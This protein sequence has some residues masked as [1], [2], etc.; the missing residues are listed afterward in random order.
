MPDDTSDFSAEFRTVETRMQAAADARLEARREVDE[1]VQLVCERSRRTAAFEACEFSVKGK[2]INVV[3]GKHV[4]AVIAS[5]GGQEF[6]IT[7]PGAG[8]IAGP[9]NIS[10]VG[11]AIAGLVLE[12]NITQ[13]EAV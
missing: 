9:I 8:K 12:D 7:R 3:R 10:G 13:R 4:I 1:A 2:S 5:V 6:E 11:E